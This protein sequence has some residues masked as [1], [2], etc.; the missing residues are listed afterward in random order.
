MELVVSKL[1]CS[2]NLLHPFRKVGIN[3]NPTVTLDNPIHSLQFL[4]VINE[5][6]LNAKFLGNLKR[7]TCATALN[8]LGAFLCY[9]I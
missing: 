9:I 4:K 5:H 3:E 8:E 1:V 6:N 7:I 2:N